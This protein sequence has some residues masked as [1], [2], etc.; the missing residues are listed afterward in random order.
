LDQLGIDIGTVSVK[1]LRWRGKK[2][3]GAIISKG[4]YPYTGDFGN[5]AEILDDIIMK[6]GNELDVSIGLTSQDIQKRI[7]TIPILPKN[8]LKDALKWSVSKVISTPLEEMNYE[9]SMLGEVDERGTKKQEVLFTGIQKT[10]ADNILSVVSRTGFRK[11]SLLTDVAFTFAPVVEKDDKNS[12]AVIDVG[13]RQSGIYIFDDRK[14]RFVREIM[15]ASESFT[16][17]LMSGLNLSY[18]EA[19][20]YKRDFGFH[21]EALG[22]LSI[23]LE[24]LSG[25]IQRTFSV[26]NQRYPEKPVK[27]VFITGGGAKIPGFS[28]KLKELLIEEIGM[29]YPPVE[30]DDEFLPVYVLCVYPGLLINIL[31][32][33]IK[34]IGKQ[35]VYKKWTRIGTVAV[36][37]VLIIFSLNVLAKINRINISI[38][39][40]KK[41]IEGKRKQHIEFS[42]IAATS[43]GYNEF[44]AIQNEIKT[45]DDTFI[46]LM[47]FLS[48][49]L[50]ESIHLKEI[51]F[52]K[53][54]NVMAG[55]SKNPIREALQ[56]DEKAI[57]E[58]MKVPGPT[59]DPQKDA[60]AALAARKAAE[61]SEKG[62]G[63][64]ITGY[65]YGDVDLV[66][67]SLMN[68]LVRLNKMGFLYN[69]DIAQKEI[70][71]VKG[72]NALEFILTA[73]CMM[74]EI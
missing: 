48:A 27:N 30:V 7:F 6:E 57:K 28:S 22:A 36:V 29:L 66:E 9:F 16:D 72:Q 4:S 52:D 74:Y 39:T 50:P 24:R 35:E 41:I 63:V 54:G 40:E 32:E 53:Y 14:L 18:D 2:G 11:I 8:E 26:Y 67:A 69:V 37:A 73:R 42:K 43:T 44:V 34:A 62:Y 64:K 68:V 47:K 51:E 38:Q 1:Y 46:A 12:V 60:A 56:K 31:P 45:K 58:S 10:D 21:D 33:E 55:I 15:T 5:L 13:G 25:E 49:N 70:K 61:A 20:K 59:G 65:I 17:A 71:D 19:E 23:P 3:K